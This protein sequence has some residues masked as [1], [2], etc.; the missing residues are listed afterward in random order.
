VKIFVISLARLPERLAFMRVGLERLGIAYE[1]FQ[2]VDGL[3]GEHEKISRY[4]EQGCL[5]R[6][7][8]PLTP[9]E[10][11][12]FASHFLLWQRCEQLREPIT[13]IED[14]VLLSPA[15]VDVLVLAAARIMEHR[16]IRLATWFERPERP[17]RII[18]VIGEHRRLVRFLRGPGGTQCYCLSPD[19]AA[20]LLASSQR[21]IEPVDQHIDRFWKHGVESK[22]LLPFEAWEVEPTSLPQGIGDRRYC[23]KGFAKL[24]RE[25]G[26][27]SDT[28]AR[29]IYSLTHP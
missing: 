3:R 25:W 17:F 20:A 23:R 16:F 6:F 28:A 27:I 14:D 2:A 10:I 22:A 18:E 13:I 26:R 8:A 24:S 29:T 1:I 21:W 11:G 15:F 12:C 7:G 4:D 5:R 9:G 19:G